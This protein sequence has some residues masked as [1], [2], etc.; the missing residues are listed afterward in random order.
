MAE[1]LLRI[2]NH[3]KESNKMRMPNCILVLTTITLCACSEQGPTRYQISGEVKFN[4]EPLAYGD[5]LF[6]PDG[7][8]GNSGPQGVAFI[9]NG[10]YDTRNTDGKGIAGGA[11]VIQIRGLNAQGGKLICN[12]VTSID[13]P[14]ENGKHNIDIPKE[15]ATKEIKKPVPEI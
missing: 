5:V 11:T 9:K 3:I 12:Y 15:A 6:T 8:K 10:F 13:L 7:A 4:G 14:K 2:I 1:K